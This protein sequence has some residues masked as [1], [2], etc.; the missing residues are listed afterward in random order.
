MKIKYISAKYVAFCHWNICIVFMLFPLF[1]HGQESMTLE[2]CRKMALEN[3]KQIAIAEQN[4]E[5][6]S[7]TVKAY[8]ANFLPR[9]SATGLAY[10]T[11]A[12]N[13]FKVK[14]DNI[15]LFNPDDLNG[16]LPPNLLPVVSQFSTISIPDMNF[17]LNLNNSYLVGVSVEQ[18]IFM[19]GKITSAYKMA[20]TGND[21]AKQNQKL[22][23]TEVIQ[24]T[25]E[26]YWMYVK[27]T[28]LK[29]SSEK[30]KK[31]VT[32][33]YRVVENAQKTGMKSQN[34]VMKVQVKL[35][36]AELQLLQAENGTRLARM[37]LC[38]IIGIHL[39]SEIMLPESFDYALLSMDD[40]VD[41]TSRPEYAML[42]KRVQLKEQEKKLV[43]SEFLPNIGVR[44][45]YNYMYGLKLNDEVLMDNTSFSAMISVNI[46][47]FH[48]GEGAN[49]IRIAETEKKI[50]QIQW[51]EATEKM[52]LELTQTLNRYEE[53]ILEIQLTAN[54][55]KQAEENLKI[56][57]NHYDVGMETLADYLEAQTLWQKASSDFINAKAALKLS[58][59]YY[60]K[61]AGKLR[62]EE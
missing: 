3:N 59:T 41:V 11:S 30:Y 35:N 60:M 15:H 42:S 33:L 4:K 24:Q 46:P 6:A 22:T 36:E 5:K 8:R 54:S 48:W 17:N 39:L 55:L 53:S 21:I 38:H 43:R 18:P 9:I 20:K 16:I 52:Q 57:R 31:V 19:G 34:D 40:N 50:A 12:E 56:S 58:E 47:L 2:K 37:N 28:E 29:K 13:D 32:E 26:A 61:A 44:G 49:K 27:A 1:L 62:I 14:T 23:E 25:D 10:Y 51:Q 7:A 45:G